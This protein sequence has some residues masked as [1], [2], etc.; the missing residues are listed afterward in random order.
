MN[1]GLQLAEEGFVLFIVTVKVAELNMY[2]LLIGDG[3]FVKNLF[4]V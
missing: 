1:N 4:I 2:I 3:D